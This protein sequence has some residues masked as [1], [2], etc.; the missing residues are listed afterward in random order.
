MKE[1]AQKLYSVQ[2]DLRI[3]VFL[4]RQNSPKDRFSLNLM[5]IDILLIRYDIKLTDSFI[6]I[7]WSGE[8]KNPKRHL[9]SE[10]RGNNKY[11]WVPG[12]CIFQAVGFLLRYKIFLHYLCVCSTSLLA[13]ADIGDFGL[14]CCVGFTVPAELCPAWARLC[15]Y[16]GY[17]WLTRTGI[18]VPA[19]MGNVYLTCRWSFLLTFLIC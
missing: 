5:H 18:L 9:A 17:Q 6:D 8:E 16:H 4:V 1:R 2:T 11:L 13:S 3:L 10:T 19:G 14:K 7:S 12:N 15:G